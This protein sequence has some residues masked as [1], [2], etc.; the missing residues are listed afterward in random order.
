[1]TIFSKIDTG[2]IILIGTTILG[3]LFAVWQIILKRRFE[4][5]DKL[6]DRRYEAYQGFMKL[7]DEISYKI[8]QDPQNVFS[9]MNRYFD[10]I[11]S[12]NPDDSQ[13][14]LSEFNNEIFTFTQKSLEPLQIVNAELSKLRLICS[15]RLLVKIDEYKLLV[16]SISNSTTSNLGLIVKE[17]EKYFK[18]I[19]SIN[20]SNDM[21]RMKPLWDEILEMMRKELNI[22]N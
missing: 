16:E 20:D 19:K 10:G 13:K 5:N 8:R 6:I 1:M 11:L 15:K 4:K 17:P 3:F 22:K 7:A 2:H 21:K 18:L 9:L 12:D 14:A